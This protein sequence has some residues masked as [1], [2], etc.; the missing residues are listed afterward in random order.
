M[1]ILGGQT[2]YF[3]MHSDVDCADSDHNEPYEPQPDLRALHGYDVGHGV[4]AVN[5]Y[6]ETSMAT[7]LIF[8]FVTFLAVL[9]ANLLEGIVRR[10]SKLNQA[11]IELKLAEG[12]VPHIL[13]S[14]AA[15]LVAGHLADSHSRNFLFVA[16]L[17]LG[18]VPNLLMYFAKTFEQLFFL[19]MFTGITIGGLAP[20]TCS[21]A[22]DMFPVDRRVVMLALWT[23]GL[24]AGQQLGPQLVGL[25]QPVYGPK[26]PFLA[27][28]VPGLVSS[29][30]VHLLPEPMRAAQEQAFKTRINPRSHFGENWAYHRP[31][32]LAKVAAG[33]A[34]PT[35]IL[36]LAQLLPGSIAWS[37]VTVKLQP[38][39]TTA[40]D[41]PHAAAAK[42]LETFKVTNV[43]GVLISGVIGQ[44]AYNWAPYALPL[45]MGI[46]SLLGISPLL[47]ILQSPP[48]PTDSTHLNF[49]A[50]AAGALLAVP[51]ATLQIC[52]LNVSKP[53][54]R[55]TISG[56]YYALAAAGRIFGPLGL[57]A[58][59]V[60]VG[61][62]V[63]G[64]SAGAWAFGV[65]GLAFLAQAFTLGNDQW[66]LQAALARVLEVD[67][68]ML[69]LN[70]NTPPAPGY[71]PAA[72]GPRCPQDQVAD[73]IAAAANAEFAAYGAREAERTRER[74]AAWENRADDDIIELGSDTECEIPAPNKPLD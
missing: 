8:I 72:R 37:L 52:L 53:E 24:M 25:I 51:L 30:V 39:L 46:G 5:R 69:A 3:E 2:S 35:V 11:E 58:V 60:A 18:K 42:V 14:A 28:T 66:Q 34:V 33:L 41:M 31:V 16:L 54:V 9:D 19:N 12:R 36:S 4:R 22:S 49:W 71:D 45:F 63:T 68:E 70:P 47:L 62:P 10:D 26:M 20:L 21:L 64:L 55:G 1:P 73:D 65:C 13:I 23:A 29:F 32:A 50:A 7:A 74:E 59:V 27:L 38:F 67:M 44:V 43:F 15:S 57:A 56:I 61:H 6:R 17:L 48:D 40:K